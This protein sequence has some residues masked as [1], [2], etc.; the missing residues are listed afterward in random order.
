MFFIFI[1]DSLVNILV[2]PIFHSDSPVSSV[3]SARGWLHGNRLIK[4]P[5]CE[6]VTDLVNLISSSIS[7]ATTK[8]Y[9]RY[10]LLLRS[11]LIKW[12]LPVSLPILPIWVAL[13][14]TDLRRTGKAPSTIQSH[15][16]AI[17]YI[18]KCSELVDPVSSFLVQKAMTGVRKG[19]VTMDTRL[20]ITLPLLQRLCLSLKETCSSQY[21]RI[22]F[23][24]MF[25]LAFFAFLRVG[26]ITVSQARVQ[27]VIN[28]S[29]IHFQSTNGSLIICFKHFKHSLGRTHYVTVDEQVPLC[30]VQSL[31]SYLALRGVATGYLFVTSSG[32]PISRY[33]FTQQLHKCIQFLSLDASVYK[34]H[35]FRIGAATHFASVGWSDSKIRH[36]GRWNSNAF[37]KYIRLG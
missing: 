11:F 13:Y 30:P 7:P 26:E 8:A 3:S 28:L 16:S 37:G 25:S 10:L 34:T 17:S 2:F 27:N 4:T 29:Q 6:L 20:P 12:Q 9:Q 32:L 31:R 23:Q 19:N 18:H 22:M 35:S 36:H 21:D 15:L 1:F 24:A 14:I 33:I 5:V